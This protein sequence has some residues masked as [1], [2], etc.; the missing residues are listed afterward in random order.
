LIRLHRGEAAEGFAKPLAYAHGRFGIGPLVLR[1]T[2]LAR[3][4]AADRYMRPCTHHLDIGCG[5]GYFLRRSP[6]DERY[7]IDKMLGDDLGSRL[8]FPDGALGCVSMLAV[9]E[10]LKSPE[11]TLREIHRVLEP[12]GLLIITTPKKAAEPLIRLYVV[13]IE[14]EHETYF[15][16]ASIERLA[17][18]LFELAGHHTFLLG[19]NQAFCLRKPAK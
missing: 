5:D 3:A 6:A 14:D 8:D 16:L 18:G 12:G 10:H 11:E 2:R 7:G 19:L 4:R 15:D 9:I 17:S 13:D 1:F